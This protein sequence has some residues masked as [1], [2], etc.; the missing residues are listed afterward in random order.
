MDDLSV[1][2]V[3]DNG[4][5]EWL[6]LRSLRKAGIGDVT[7]ARDG[8]EAVR[9]LHGAPAPCRP[10]IVFLD[11]RLPGLDGVEVLQ[12][13]R[14]DERTREVRVVVLSSSE[15][16]HDKARCRELGVTEFCPKP[17]SIERLAELGLADG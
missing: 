9:L 17:L 3:E 6:A 10:G 13:I 2:L 11:L 5:D 15:D 7:V 1:L 14:T 16:P 8:A 4:D 12:R